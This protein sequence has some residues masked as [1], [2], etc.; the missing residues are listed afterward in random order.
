MEYRSSIT[1]KPGDVLDIPGI[2]TRLI[3]TIDQTKHDR[4]LIRLDAKFKPSVTISVDT[5]GEHRTPERHE[6]RIHS[7][8]PEHIREDLAA[9]LVAAL[10]PG[11]SD[12]DQAR[13]TAIV[14]SV[15]EYRDAQQSLREVLAA[16]GPAVFG[17]MALF[18][19]EAQSSLMG[20]VEALTHPRVL[21]QM[22]YTI[23]DLGWPTDVLH[24]SYLDQ[25][26]EDPARDARL[27][28]AVLAWKAEHG[29]ATV[30]VE[31]TAK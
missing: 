5:A 7:R 31:G 4:Y 16:F 2:G 20:H 23:R 26:A 17:T 9:S 6:P 24:E 29:A 15:N 14:A 10:G 30:L 8:D 28:E 25:A 27:S 1:L 13:A 22:G 19:F 3:G 18:H 12:A 11:G 21:T